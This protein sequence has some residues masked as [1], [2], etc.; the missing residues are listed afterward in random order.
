MK[1]KKKRDQLSG[2]FRQV[3]SDIKMYIEKRLELTMLNLGEHIAGWMATSLQRAAGGLLLLL[4]LCFLLVAL[5]I[6]LG[7]L[8][9]IRSLGYVV[10]SVLLLLPGILFVYLKPQGLFKNLQHSF[11]EKFMEAIEQDR[12]PEKKKLESTESK[13]AKEHKEQ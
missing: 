1:N 7:A 2:K 11:E 3:T 9:G 8:I 4:G 13:H 5:A 10:V 12:K 6:Y